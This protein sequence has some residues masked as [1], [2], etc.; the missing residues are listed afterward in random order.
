MVKLPFFRLKGTFS[1]K[2]DSTSAKMKLGKSAKCP[3]SRVQP[4][5]LVWAAPDPTAFY[6]LGISFTA[7]LRKWCKSRLLQMFACC[8]KA[9]ITIASIFILS[10]FRHVFAA[11]L[12]SSFLI[13]VYIESALFWIAVKHQYLGLR[14]P[15]IH[16]RNGISKLAI[17]SFNS[18]PVLFPPCQP[19]FLPPQK[20]RHPTSLTFVSVNSSGRKS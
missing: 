11:V 1:G 16:P 18:S 7:A 10:K 17:S 6:K 14:C 20:L 2:N 15:P 13:S 12:I 19:T 3:I 5:P 8:L 4:L 9:S